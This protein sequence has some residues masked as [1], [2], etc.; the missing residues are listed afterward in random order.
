MAKKDKT[1]ALPGMTGKGIAPL[2]IPAIDKAINSYERKKEKRCQA[3]P[4]EVSAK[5]D[6][7]A[8]LAKHRDEL[9]ANEDGQRFY[10]YEGVDYIVDVVLKRRAADD[11]DVATEE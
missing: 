8:L 6:L 11:G 10:R 5:R 3:S 4:G 9:P 1:A 7:T 2:S